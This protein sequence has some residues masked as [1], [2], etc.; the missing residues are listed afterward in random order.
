MQLSSELNL[1]LNVEKTQLFKWLKSKDKTL[2]ERLLHIREELSKWVPHIT[3][4]F[5]HYPSHGL[6]HSD[7][8]IEQLSRLLFNNTRPV[9]AFSTAE[10]YCL[11]SAAYLHD[12]G[13]VVSPGD[14]TTILGSEQW[15]AFV[16]HE[17]K[18]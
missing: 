10:V 5:P 18:G 11:L 15:K 7:R 9:V 12:I 16:V 8:I 1:K 3:Q 4:F 2:A 14:V 17:G 6:D 13:M